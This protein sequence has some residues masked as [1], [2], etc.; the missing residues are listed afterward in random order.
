MT[1]ARRLFVG[2]AVCV[3]A[4]AA[5]GCSDNQTSKTS[6]SPPPSSAGKSPSSPGR[7]VKE[8]EQ[9][10]R[11]QAAVEVVPPDDPAFVES[12]LERVAD[13]VHRNSALTPGKEYKL[14]VA[15]IGQGRMKIA[16]QDKEGELSCDAVPWVQRIQQAPGQLPI[17]ITA[18]AGA[19]GMVAW[20][21]T[22]ATT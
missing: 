15:C 2:T 11:A 4:V 20:Q 6:P 17:D 12:G 22:R 7:A 14:S 16:V 13:G 19:S 18:D 21:I 10:R 8:D 3:L 9:G 1:A 5:T